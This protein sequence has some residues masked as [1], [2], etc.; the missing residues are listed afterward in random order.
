MKIRDLARDEVVTASPD[1][2]V[3]EIASL[4]RE[5]NVGSVVIT[6]DE[7]PVGIVTD[8]DITVDV[9]AGELDARNKTAED[10]MSERLIF[11]EAD[12]D[13]YGVIQ[14]TSDQTVR[15]IPVVD[16]G[17]LTGIVTFDDLYLHYVTALQKLSGVVFRES[18]VVN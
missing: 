11:A 7:K 1:T 17:K 9:V 2:S 15:R 14:D 16:D 5:K 6:E 8:R 18:R 3:Y 4:M 13:V 10:V 12:Q